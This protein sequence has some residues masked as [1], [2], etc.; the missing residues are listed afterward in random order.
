MPRL[1]HVSTR[2]HVHGDPWSAVFGVMR[3][4]CGDRSLQKTSNLPHL[5]P[6][7]TNH[8][9]NWKEQLAPVGHR[10]RL[11]K[12]C[13]VEKS[14]PLLFLR[15]RSILTPGRLFGGVIL[16]P[17][18]PIPPL[19]IV[20]G[21]TIDRR[22]IMGGVLG[23]RHVTSRIDSMAPFIIGRAIALPALKFPP[24]HVTYEIARRAPTPSCVV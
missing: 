11:R 9:T 14:L 18:T 13:Y 8:Y 5:F 4:G 7:V 20:V 19:Y 21:R 23:D 1:R 3:R 17:P 2:V 15:A 24:I 10:I 12:T 22:T 6:A 16:Y